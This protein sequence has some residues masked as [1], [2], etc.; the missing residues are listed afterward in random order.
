MMIQGLFETCLPLSAL[1]SLNDTMPTA[2]M[3]APETHIHL[4]EIDKKKSAPLDDIRTDSTAP[5]FSVFWLDGTLAG[6][7][8]ANG[9]FEPNEANIRDGTVFGF[10]SQRVGYVDNQQFRSSGRPRIWCV[11]PETR[12]TSMVA[13]GPAEALLKMA[14]H[15]NIETRCIDVAGNNFSSW[16]G[17]GSRLL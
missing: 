1:D 6:R 11:L 13:D 2:E 9:N 7:V 16:P 4:N 12:V 5:A 8:I 17:C 3:S 15:R 14:K 10:W